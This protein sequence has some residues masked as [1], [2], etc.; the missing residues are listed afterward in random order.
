ME[1]TVIFVSVLVLL[2][3]GVVALAWIISA[4][5]RQMQEEASLRS[6]SVNR[7]LIHV[8]RHAQQLTE[9]SAKLHELEKQSPTR[10]AAE[11]VSLGDAVER[12]RQTQQRFQGR[13]DA[14][15]RHHRGDADPGVGANPSDDD[16]L[17]AML[18]LQGNKR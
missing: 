2:V 6:T 9:I 17:N 8:D 16:E 13:F 4:H 14:D 3:A 5:K 15:R 1:T 10:L 12:L 7:L 18:A 11:V